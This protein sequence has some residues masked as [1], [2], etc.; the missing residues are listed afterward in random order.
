MQNFHDSDLPRHKLFNQLIESGFGGMLDVAATG[1][2]AGNAEVLWFDSKAPMQA[3]R[4]ILNVQEKAE[5]S[6]LVR[7]F[8]AMV[9]ISGVDAAA[10][11]L[12]TPFGQQDCEKREDCNPDRRGVSLIVMDASG[13]DASFFSYSPGETEL[14]Y[15]ESVTESMMQDDPWLS[16][17]RVF[18][19]SYEVEEDSEEYAEALALLSK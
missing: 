7:V 4:A 16:M 17:S 2:A 15:E 5:M 8:A 11:V 14:E 3:Y 9:K 19:E 10:F 6:G 1:E 18:A 12:Y 13:L